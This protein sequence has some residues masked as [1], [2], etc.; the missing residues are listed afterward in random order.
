MTWFR[1][2]DDLHDHDKTMDLETGPCFDSAISLWARAASWSSR[3]NK[4]GF[5][6]SGAA[7][8]LSKHPDAPSELVRVGFWEAVEGGYQFRNWRKYNPAPETITEKRQ[9]AVARKQRYRDRR[10]AEHTQTSFLEPNPLSDS[11]DTERVPDVPKLAEETLCPR[12][13][14]G[15]WDLRS[16]LSSEISE[17]PP[18]QVASKV[19]PI[20]KSDP[21]PPP[22]DYNSKDLTEDFSR[23]HHA[24]G[25][26]RWKPQRSDYDRLQHALEC[27]REE[28]PSDPR[29][30]ALKAISNYLA[31]TGDWESRRG[32]P[33]EDFAKSPGRWFA[34][35]Q[36]KTVRKAATFAPEPASPREEIERDARNN[37]P[38]LCDPI[39]A[40]GAA[41]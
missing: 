35:N 24:A 5:V 22:P 7:K 30:A 11:G 38:E 20:R 34:L 36:P 1:L 23:L 27:L 6:P 14:P 19:V 26:G 33:F 21:P 31:Y 39:I 15:N 2:S 8:A 37:P 40:V 32:Y 28:S 18:R 4:G 16:D 12:V 17:Q 9:M 10:A 13:P 41:E 25:H 29:T 3:A